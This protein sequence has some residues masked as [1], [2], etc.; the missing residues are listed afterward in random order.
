[1]FRW[2]T[3]SEGDI[4]FALKDAATVTLNEIDPATVNCSS[5]A[6]MLHVTRNKLNAGFSF[7]V[8]LGHCVISQ[9]DGDEKT[10]TL[11]D[12][13][14]YAVIAVSNCTGPL[15]PEDDDLGF[16]IITGSFHFRELD[17]GHADVVSARIKCA[18]ATFKKVSSEAFEAHKARIRATP[19]S[20]YQF[21]SPFLEN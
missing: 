9:D 1:M 16:V 8:I 5:F 18:D 7:P 12:P 13:T 20:A 10:M 2:S 15:Y 4:F 17:L 11:M 21:E 19:S 6:S 14:G 3:S